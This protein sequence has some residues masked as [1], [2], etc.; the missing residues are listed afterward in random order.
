MNFTG[1]AKVTIPNAA[2]VN[3][4]RAISSKVA[5]NSTYTFAFTLPAKGSSYFS[6]WRGLQSGTTYKVKL[7]VNASDHFGESYHTFKT[8]EPPSIGSFEVLK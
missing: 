5:Q 2:K 4:K 1:F 3:C 6:D 8:N 7:T